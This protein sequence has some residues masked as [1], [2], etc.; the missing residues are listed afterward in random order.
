MEL[1]E[2][3]Q[4]SKTVIRQIYNR[5]DE[6]DK[7]ID[8]EKK[9]KIGTPSREIQ[10]NDCFMV[11]RLYNLEL[12]IEPKNLFCGQPKLDINYILNLRDVYK[13]Q[14]LICKHAFDEIDQDG[15]YGGTIADHQLEFK[16][17]YAKTKDFSSKI[18]AEKKIRRSKKC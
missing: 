2:Y 8:H 6:L 14:I 13:R 3:K 4:M 17:R 7:A 5:E 11:Q 10:C 18:R 15:F 12:N 9:N 16:L 1:E